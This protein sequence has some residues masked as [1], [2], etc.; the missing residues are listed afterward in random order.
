MCFGQVQENWPKKGDI[1]EYLGLTINF[2][3]K[4]NPDEPNKTGQVVFTMFDYIEDIVASA[5][6]DMRGIALDPTKSKLFDVHKTVPS[7]NSREADEFH[8]MTA[9]LLLAAKRARPDIQVA[10][11]FL[12][13]RVI[14]PT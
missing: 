8:S 2:S 7:L 5:P 10:V 4:Y 3:G 1:H 14:E 9:R 12:C 11:V 13:T 6:S